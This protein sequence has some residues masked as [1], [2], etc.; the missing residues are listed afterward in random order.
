M[1]FLFFFNKIKKF[2]Y[3]Y[4]LPNK[5]TNGGMAGPDPLLKIFISYC[6]FVEHFARALPRL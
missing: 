5:K 6:F 4:L 2:S 1:K 3:F